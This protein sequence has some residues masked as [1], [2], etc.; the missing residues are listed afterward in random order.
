VAKGK[1]NGPKYA[2]IIVRFNDGRPAK[3][4]SQKEGNYQVDLI[5]M[6]GD[7]SSMTYKD[8]DGNIH[9]DGDLPA[10]EYRT[11]RKEWYQHGVQ[12]RDDGKPAVTG[13]GDEYWVNGV[14]FNPNGPAVDTGSYRRYN[15]EKGELHRIG[16]PAIECTDQYAKL[17]NEYWVDGQQHCVD[18]PSSHGKKWEGFQPNFHINGERIFCKNRHEFR[19]YVSSLYRSPCCIP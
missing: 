11:G 7:W 14:L 8:A 12:H 10:V 15:N 2:R 3:I 17:K 13:K 19:Q 18:G 5:R 16:G 1:G 4:F 9:R 6:S